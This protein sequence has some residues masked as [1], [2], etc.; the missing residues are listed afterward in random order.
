M[1]NLHTFHDLNPVS[2][3]GETDRQ[4]PWIWTWRSSISDGRKTSGRVWSKTDED[5]IFFFV[6]TK[7]QPEQERIA[8]VCQTGNAIALACGHGLGFR[9]KDPMD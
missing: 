4:V 8:G 3:H 6:Y 7:P 2:G 5:Q 1:F 9:R